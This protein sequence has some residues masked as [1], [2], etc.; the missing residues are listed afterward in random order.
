MYNFNMSEEFVTWLND[1]LNK[2]GWSNSELGRRANKSP[3]A[4]SMVLSGQNKPG[5][6]LCHGIARA[7]GIPSEQVFR[8][9]ELMPKLP[10]SEN[11]E[12]L[13]NLLELVRLM[14]VEERREI[15]KYAHFRRQEYLAEAEA[16][17]KNW[18]EA[19]L[20]VKLLTALEQMQ[21]EEWKHVIMYLRD[22][23]SK[24]LGGPPIGDIETLQRALRQ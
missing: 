8:L 17:K 22:R 5:W 2:R 7:F 20:R 6:D 1:E 16:K 24:G 3:A 15:L 11:E 10:A 19:S 18:K 12:T 14:D 23:A 13:Q 4:I 21:P 9:T